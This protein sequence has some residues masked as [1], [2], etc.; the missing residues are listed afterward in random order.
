MKK[1]LQKRTKADEKRI[2][3]KS[4]K[5]KNDQLKASIKF[6][7]LFFLLSATNFLTKHKFR[8]TVAQN[9]RLFGIHL[10]VQHWATA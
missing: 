6:F 7:H 9:A 3:R 5:L 4:I 10:T 8:I 2:L 1:N